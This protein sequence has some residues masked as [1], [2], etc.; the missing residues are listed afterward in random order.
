MPNWSSNVLVVE[1]D[2]TFFDN[3]PSKGFI[4]HFYP[5]PEELSPPQVDYL[6]KDKEKVEEQFEIY[7]AWENDEERKAKAKE[8]YGA[9]DWY[10]WRLENWDTK[11]D[12]DT[13]DHEGHRVTF[14]TAWSPPIKWL[15]KVSEQHPTLT[16]T[17]AYIEQGMQFAG[18]ATATAGVVVDEDLS[19]LW[20]ESTYNDNKGQYEGAIEDF[21]DKWMFNH[22]GG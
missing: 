2:D 7:K 18:V 8:K 6:N 17:L 12:A 22:Y 20:D 3:I 10:E 11:W 1:G 14:D 9:T 21:Y 16:F 15:A 4:N 19:S 5:M 13:V